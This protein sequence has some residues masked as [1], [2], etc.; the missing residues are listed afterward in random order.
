MNLALKADEGRRGRERDA[1]LAGTG[2]SDH[3]GLA[4]AF[5]QQRLSEGVID[6]GRAGVSQVFALEIDLRAAQFF[7]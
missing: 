1:V 5:C 4:H 7:G 3:L 6:L 2:L